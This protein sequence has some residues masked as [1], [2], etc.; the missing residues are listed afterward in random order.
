MQDHPKVAKIYG[1]CP[2]SGYVVMELCEKKLGDEIVHTLEDL[3]VIYGAE[4]SIDL[5]LFALIDII[6][7]IE[8]LHSNGKI[9][10]DTKPSNV[11]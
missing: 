4:M 9:H 3:T 8:F 11:W 7:G 1:L 10:G 5:S 6:E 2:L